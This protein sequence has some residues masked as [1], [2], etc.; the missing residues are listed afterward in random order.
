M[1]YKNKHSTNK[2]ANEI[3][4][5]IFVCSLSSTTTRA[6][7]KKYFS[8]F[9][10]LT[11][12]KISRKK[13]DMRK[14]TALVTFKQ[15]QSISNVLKFKQNIHKQTGFL[16]D[17]YLKGDSLIR[18]NANVG[19]A[20]IY[21]GYIPMDLTDE[22]FEEIFSVYGEVKLCYINRQIRVLDEQRVKSYFGFVT[23]SREETA[24]RLTKT[25]IIPIPDHILSNIRI[26][27]YVEQK[28]KEWKEK[29]KNPHFETS[30]NKFLN[31][32]P[33]QGHLQIK[34][35]KVRA[36]KEKDQ[37][38][39]RP[40]E[41]NKTTKFKNQAHAPTSPQQSQN[42]GKFS[43]ART[44][45]PE[46]S[47]VQYPIPVASNNRR[48][49]R[50]YPGT[51]HYDFENERS[52]I[53]EPQ[54]KNFY[55]SQSRGRNYNNSYQNH[56]PVYSDRQYEEHDHQ[57]QIRERHIIQNKEI[58]STPQNYNCS[59]PKSEN[60]QKLSKLQLIY[61][62]YGARGIDRNHQK[63]N[64]RFNVNNKVERMIFQVSK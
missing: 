35:F 54:F 14:N 25:G 23:F 61:Q 58:Q 22:D 56:S 26:P 37:N 20:R 52:F 18:R 47:K 51:G 17:R 19:L 60:L 15:N 64:L 33:K 28:T 53:S 46:H 11:N 7:I 55:V 8:K 39:S 16:V 3:N 4:R 59:D 62:S 2:K 50:N 13:T 24:T 49:H 34:P 41:A 32:V 57:Y 31:D 43:N 29:S 10:K 6:S 1:S 45:H 48:N 40:M 63:V 27:N 44:N 5:T 9:G 12:I 38:D 42:S 30:L 21:V 36:P